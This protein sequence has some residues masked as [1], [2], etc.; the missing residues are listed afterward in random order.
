MAKRYFVKYLEPRFDLLLSSN[1][2]FQ[3][4]TSFH[5]GLNLSRH[6]GHTT[7]RAALAW[8]DNVNRAAGSPIAEYAGAFEP[9]DLE[10]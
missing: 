10:S 6:C 2:T 5:A 4:R 1:P 8:V 7:K 9:R 3:M